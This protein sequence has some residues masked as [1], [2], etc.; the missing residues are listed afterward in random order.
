MCMCVC[1][2]VCVCVCVYVCVC[3]AYQKHYIE[4][5]QEVHDQLIKLIDRTPLFKIAMARAFKSFQVGVAM[6][7]SVLPLRLL[8]SLS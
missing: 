3:V 1:V 5:E 7:L 2:Y 8:V 4:K 6:L